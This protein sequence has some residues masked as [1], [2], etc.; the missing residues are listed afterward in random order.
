MV[1]SPNRTLALQP[2]SKA[3]V[4]RAREGQSF[5]SLH[6]CLHSN[7]GTGS[8]FTQFELERTLV[9]Q[10]SDSGAITTASGAAARAA[11]TAIERKRRIDSFADIT[12]VFLFNL[13]GAIYF[14]RP[15]IWS[16]WPSSR[17]PPT[18][19]ACTTTG[20]WV[21]TGSSSNARRTSRKPA[22]PQCMC[23]SSEWS[24]STWACSTY[25]QPTQPGLS[26][27]HYRPALLP[28]RAGSHFP[29]ALADSPTSAGTMPP[30]ATRRRTALYPQL[31]P[32]PHR[33]SPAAEV[34]QREARADDCP[35]QRRPPT[36]T[37]ST[38]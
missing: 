26:W 25:R 20:G 17:R 28:Q 15:D 21:S 13:V 30:R 4:K 38:Q 3:L 33:L 19:H 35:R 10:V 11:Q 1:N 5:I 36:P 16:C 23:Y 2:L 24:T 37:A 6:D 27:R 12:E 14:D 9:M 31:T 32:L 7:A 18:S 22:Q 8:S 34:G 29:P